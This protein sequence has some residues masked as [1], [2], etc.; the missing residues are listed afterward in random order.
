MRDL[1]NRLINFRL[2]ALVRTEFNQIRRDRRLQLSLILPPVLQLTLFGFALS[3]NVSMSASPWWTTAE[4]RRAASWS[5][6]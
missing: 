1:L 2:L 5:P 4:R 3:A 6:R